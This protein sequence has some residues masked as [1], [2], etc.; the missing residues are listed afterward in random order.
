MLWGVPTMGIADIQ[1]QRP[2]AGRPEMA[3]GVAEKAVTGLCIFPSEKWAEPAAA[4]RKCKR[5]SL[6]LSLG[7]SRRLRKQTQELRRCNDPDQS[8]PLMLPGRGL[9]VYPSAGN[10]RWRVFPL[11]SIAILLAALGVSTEL[12]A[13]TDRRPDGDSTGLV[14]WTRE[15]SEEAVDYVDRMAVEQGGLEGSCHRD[16]LSADVFAAASGRRQLGVISRLASAGLL[17]T[18]GAIIERLHGP[19]R[20]LG[21]VTAAT[22]VSNLV[23]L[24]L[25]CTDLP[26]LGSSP[27]VFFG[28]G[29][30]SI[31]RPFSMW[32]CLPNLPIPCQWLLAPAV[33]SLATRAW[34]LLG[35]SRSMETVDEDATAP[36]PYE[37]LSNRE[38]RRL[39]SRTAVQLSMLEAT[40]EGE[41]DEGRSIGV[42][43]ATTGSNSRSEINASLASLHDQLEALRQEWSARGGWPSDRYAGLISFL[44]LEKRNSCFVN[45]NT[46]MLG[47]RSEGEENTC[48]EA[49]PVGVRG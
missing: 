1:F 29:Y 18:S 48:V 34:R 25:S 47:V 26:L 28:V 2:L 31:L 7:S 43:Y 22:A 41:V 40:Q 4:L 32:A 21:A 49:A 14:E 12:S 8:R 38:L 35:S 5:A 17:L 27:A 11:G 20:F 42:L 10:S 3:G 15:G 45:S 46:I 33:V 36:R 30:L 24:Q 44:A 16:H 13:I 6:R 39:M 9:F 19:V 23:G 37:Q